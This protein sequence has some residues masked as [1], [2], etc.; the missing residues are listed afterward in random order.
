MVGLLS[1]SELAALRDDI[2]DLLPDTC[3]VKRNGTADRY[4]DMSETTVG[5]AVACRFDP[6]SRSG[7]HV[8][9][10]MEMTSSYYR[11]TLT[12]NEDVAP[13]DVVTYSSD[14]YDVLEVHQD[15]SLKAS[16]R[17]MVVRRD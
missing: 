16:T 14:D 17:C 15:H 2:N 10:D 12:Y 7:D 1:A 9:A 6:V 13:G 3:D 4:G 11:V 8:E 5:T